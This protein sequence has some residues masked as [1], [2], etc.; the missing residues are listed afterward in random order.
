MTSE[1]M[2]YV[3]WGNKVSAYVTA[4]G[5]LIVCALVIT[6]IKVIIRKN[7]SRW[8]EKTSSSIDDFLIRIVINFIVP[9]AYVGTVYLV[10]SGLVLSIFTRKLVVIAATALLTI[11]TARLFTMLITYGFQLYIFRRGE[12]E[13]LERSLKGIVR[14]L[15]FLVWGLAIVFF[16]DNIGFEISTVIAGLGIGGV[17]VAMAAQAVLKD[18]FSYFSI[19][20][21]R[22]FEIGD[23]IVVGDFSGTVEYIGIKTTRMRSLNGEQLLIANKD[24][25]DA[26]LKNFKNMEQRRVTFNIGVTYE[27]SREK[28]LE[29]P[30][31]IKEI[32]TAIPDT[33]FGGAY[34]MS[35]G[36]YSLIF[37]VMYKVVIAD[38]TRYQEIQQEINYKLRDTFTTKGIEFAYPTQTLLVHTKEQ[39]TEEP[40]S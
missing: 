11:L 2:N 34:F 17:A 22:P 6:G 19:L 3:L 27:T 15:S 1:V 39:L 32:I 7:I 25:T 35:H 37:E 28:L 26:R 9:L 16:I 14:V 8:V 29:V 10:L 31:L 13:A 4:I 20:F 12:N 38:Y 21:D 30:G 36:P 24:L 18:L 5:V 23:F 33:D 40:Q